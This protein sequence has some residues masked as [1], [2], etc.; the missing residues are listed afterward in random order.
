M[1]NIITAVIPTY[2][3]AK[4]IW[5]CLNSLN[6]QIID[7]KY[8]EVIVILN[9]E[10][11]PYYTDIFNYIK[12]NKLSNF[13]VLYIPEIGVS[14]ARN[15]GLE[16]ATGKYIAFIDDD[17]YISST[18]FQSF[19]GIL[20]ENALF[21]ANFVNFRGGTVINTI[22]YAENDCSI[23]LLK[24]RKVFSNIGGKVIPMDII[25]GIRF[26]NAINLGEDSLFMAKISKN[27]QFIKTG[28]KSTI[29]YRRIRSQ[30]ATSKRKTVKE[31]LNNAVTLLQNYIKL[32]GNSEYNKVFL[33]A[34][35]LAILKGTT[36]SLLRNLL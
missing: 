30:S 6:N 13:R 27:I 8:Y 11:E 18:Y 15:L 35:I 10:K 31:I 34:K 12:E 19:L 16:V 20:S 26:D 23:S 7:K 25:A 17:D 24:Y 3:P 2:R 22:N 29:Y 1:E 4:Y 5:D 32:L 9:G 33:I 28:S 21:V 36:I 14:I